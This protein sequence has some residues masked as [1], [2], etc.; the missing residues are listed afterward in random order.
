MF[1]AISNND[2]LEWCLDNTKLDCDK[3]CNASRLVQAFNTQD[4]SRTDFDISMAWKHAYVDGRY[5]SE[6][7]RNRNGFGYS[8][9][10]TGC[11]QYIII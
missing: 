10:D 1:M 8:N 6:K 7:C 4:F 5:E 11:C 2:Y 9:P 3:R